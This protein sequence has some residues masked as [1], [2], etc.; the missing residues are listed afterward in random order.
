MRLQL[1]KL[2]KSKKSGE[3]KDQKEEMVETSETITPEELSQIGSD[4]D[5][6]LQQEMDSA[7]LTGGV[8][9][10]PLVLKQ[11]QSKQ[12]PLPQGELQ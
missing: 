6:P 2:K 7:E 5:Q 11:E 3:K 12:E 1:R 8:P 4:E 9:K 10:V